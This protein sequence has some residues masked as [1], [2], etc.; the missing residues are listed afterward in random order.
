MPSV[1]TRSLKK[2]IVHAFPKSISRGVDDANGEGCRGTATSFS[3]GLRLG[4]EGGSAAAFG[5]P[6]VRRVSA[7]GCGWG[8]AAYTRWGAGAGAGAVGG[9]GTGAG[10]GLL[11]EGGTGV[12][13]TDGGGATG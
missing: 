8:E 11:R 2:K 10:S 7:L 3:R 1:D 9:A 6:A 4:W 13:C 5:V 12:S